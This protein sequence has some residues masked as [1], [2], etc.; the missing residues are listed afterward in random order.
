MYHYDF[1]KYSGTLVSDQEPIKTVAICLVVVLQL[2]L[3]GIG[4]VRLHYPDLGTEVT[5][6]SS[7]C[8]THVRVTR[9]RLRGLRGSAVLSFHQLPDGLFSSPDR[10]I[11]LYDFSC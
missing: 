1:M 8:R 10:Q 6:Q 5:P 7:L 3:P 2:Y 4:S 11:T 9:R